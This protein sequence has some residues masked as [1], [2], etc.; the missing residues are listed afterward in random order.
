MEQSGRRRSAATRAQ[1]RHAELLA[2]LTAVRAQQRALESDARAF[3][4]DQGAPEKA[5]ARAAL[6]ELLT[7]APH[8][9]QLCA[10]TGGVV[11]RVANANEVA[12]KMTREVRRLDV[13]QSRLGATLARAA[14]LLRLRNAMVGVRRAMQQRRYSE[15]AAFLQELKALEQLLPLDAADRL[16]LDTIE[17]DLK[18]V[19]ESAFGDG[20]RAADRAAIRTYAPLFQAVGKDY[21][22]RGVQQLLAH[23][24]DALATELGA[25]TTGAFSTREQLAHL[26]AVFNQVAAVAQEH[27][28]LM[29]GCFVRVGGAN[30]LTQALYGIGE[31]AAVAVLGAYMQQRRFQQ[32][33]HAAQDVAERLSPTSAAAVAAAAAASASAAPRTAQAGESAG[34]AG[35]GGSSTSS[36]A[37]EDAIAVLNEQLNEVA[38]VIQHTQTYE[39]FMRSRVVPPSA[40]HDS[41]SDSDA[42]E[43]PPP[44]VLPPSHATELG[45]TVQELAGYY[46]FFEND[47]LNR[48]AHKAFQW[49]EIRYASAAP[50][51]AGDEVLTVPISSAIDEI[52]YVARNSG[53]R[54]LATGHVDCAAGVL[55]MI[56]TVLRDAL[57][58][59]MRARIRHM[60]T[61]IKLADVDSTG[62]AP[63]Q[64]RDQVQQ[65]FAKLSKTMGP[66]QL[67]TGA[68]PAPPPE[69]RSELG[70]AVVMNSLETTAE[71][72]AQIKR[73]FEREL[74][75]AFPDVPKHVVT[76]LGGL[77]DAAAEL[78]QLLVAS[79][80]K[81]CKLL[82]PKIVAALGGLLAPT[83]KRPP[84]VFELTEQMFTF[85]EANDPFA[86]HFVAC[87][88]ALLGPFRETLSS[89]NFSRL[90]ELAARTTADVLETWFV[91]QPRP[92]RF[93]QLGALQFD[94]DVRVLSAFFSESCDCREVFAPLAQT[95]AVLTVDAPD[96]VLDLVG[97]KARGVD[98]KLSPARVKEAL[99]RRVEFADAAIN[100]LNLNL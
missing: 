72:I 35:G 6:Q 63:S 9:A 68:A 81:L 64:L 25:R 45:K 58:D 54:A 74:P 8:V 1:Q 51:R 27:E 15:A 26:T 37:A 79:R 3:V 91:S 32:R 34:P 43:P 99:S 48:A 47:L 16:R 66:I 31:R 59:A 83:S 44:P 22:E 40:A 19:V 78:G 23:V 53:L 49:E 87:M 52:F 94:K 88:R 76:C 29:A 84:V 2:Q 18:S 33:M 85:N 13:V 57:G 97:R 71:Y 24:T 12:E 21:E 46:C 4:A 92:A 30:R 5:A 95:A 75:Q 77:E 50:G 90:V 11:E 14:Q 42:T 98:W 38:L 93:N 7:L 69:V 55:N 60:A 96:D 89:S 20:L 65:Q 39:R 73:E 62:A 28:P 82:E 61:H 86:H 10:Q 36:D 17:S 100:Q 80:K 56:N 70:P 41:D 67:P